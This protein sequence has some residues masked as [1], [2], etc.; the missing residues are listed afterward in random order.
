MFPNAIGA[1]GIVGMDAIDADNP[2]FQELGTNGRRCATCHRPAEGWN[3]T[4]AELRDRFDRTDGL[5]P[6][7]RTNDGSN[8][9]GADISTIGK[10]RRAFSLL[11]EKGLIRVPLDIPARAEFDLVAVEDPYRCGAPLASASM[12]RRPLPTANLKFLSAVMWMASAQPVIRDGL[13]GRSGRSHGHAQGTAPA[14]AQIRAIVDF[15][16]VPTQLVDRS[17]AA[18]PEASHPARC[19][20][21]GC[22]ALA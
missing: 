17:A 12:Y 14:P 4:P 16:S 11:L 13:V 22:S 5:D 21:R 19:T 1:V 15:D 8:C 9:E 10:R 7:F 20:V 6:I 3:I 2:F 18:W